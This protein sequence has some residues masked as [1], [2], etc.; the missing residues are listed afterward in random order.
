MERTNHS[1]F[2]SLANIAEENGVVDPAASNNWQPIDIAAGG[3]LSGID[4]ASNGTVA[5][6]AGNPDMG[7][8]DDSPANIADENG[9]ADLL[10][11]S[12]ESGS[13]IQPSF[14]VNG[15]SPIVIGDGATVVIDGASTQSITFAGMTGTLKLDNAQAFAGEVSG[16]SGADTLDLADVG[17]GPNTTA[18][19]LGN[20]SGGKLTITNGTQSASIALVGNYLS[21]DW[22]LSSDGHGGTLVVD[23]AASNNWQPID[24]GAGGFL[25]GMDIAP[26]GVMV[27][28]TDT[29]G[30]YIWNGSEWQQ[31]VT[32]TSM[33]AAFVASQ[34]GT[35]PIRASTKFRSRR[36]IQTSCT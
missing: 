22:T 2:S 3:Y 32:S 23:P 33:P 8:N 4:I 13:T 27:V 29:Y 15:A 7:R 5:V 30:A 14:A 36:A 11:S 21:S 28:R 31:L 12:D 17:Y 35:L 34:G 26:D 25:S 9:S 20:T 16:L 18:T 24:I 6:R 1:T 19:F 10:P